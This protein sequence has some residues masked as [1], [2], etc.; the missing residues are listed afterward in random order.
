LVGDSIVLRVVVNGREIKRRTLDGLS[1]N[2]GS[3][4]WKVTSLGANIGGE[5]NGI[6]RFFELGV[7]PFTLT[8][9]EIEKLVANIRDYMKLPFS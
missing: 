7:N 1:I 3:M 8:N 6:L 4:E 5:D 2:L 9:D